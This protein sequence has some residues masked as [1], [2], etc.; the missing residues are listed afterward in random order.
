[1][2]VLLWIYTISALLLSMYGLNTLLYSFLFLRGRRR[3]ADPV[4]PS[5]TEFPHVTVQLPIYNELYVVERLIDAAAALDW[6]RDKLQ[7]QVLDDSEDQT[8]QIAQARVDH[9]R[10]RGLDIELRRRADR[11]GFKA[12]ALAAGLKFATGEFITIFDADFVPPRSYLR[13]TIPYLLQKPQVG[14]V[15]GRWGHLNLDYSQLTRSQAV[16]LDSHF[17]IEQAVRS[18]QNW[19]MNFNGTAGVWRRACIESVGGWQ[20]ET[21]CEDLDLSYRAQLAGW[22]FLFLNQVVC[23]A[24]LPPQ[25]HAWKRQQFRWA[26][27]STQCLIKFAGRITMAPVPLLKRF[28]ALLHL[29]GYV[30]QPVSLLLLLA[31]VPLTI[32][33]VHFPAFLSYFS[34]FSLGLPLLYALAQR[35]LYPDWGTR[36]RVFPHLALLGMGLAF[37]N[38]LAVLEA[39]TGRH[40]AFRRTPK[41]NL[42]DSQDR[43]VQREYALAFGWESVGEI[44]LMGYALIGIVGAITTA[45]YWVVPFLCLY[46][47]GFG[48]VAWLSLWHSRL[49][50]LGRRERGQVKI[51]IGTPV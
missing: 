23:P 18:Q 11:D 5:L 37:N 34:L 10:K 7:I 20:A 27:G 30:F 15:Q 49:R 33:Q 12:G 17:V 21:L 24:E 50:S 40:S 25:I 26:K 2:S 16:L 32:Y 29:S 41:F 35:A 31:L 4:T 45:Q 36:L 3:P 46:S 14:L 38:T 51:K 8:T 13:K 47:L 42:S 44:L 39:A 48:Y 6:P 28:E 1:M 19:F 9:Y 22:K 43:W